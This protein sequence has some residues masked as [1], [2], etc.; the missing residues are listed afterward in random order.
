MALVLYKV[1]SEELE[2]TGTHILHIKLEMNVY[3]EQLV[4]DQALGHY[5]GF[6]KVNL[7]D[8]YLS[9]LCLFMYKIIK[10]WW[11]K[12]ISTLKDQL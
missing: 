2:K 1:S 4:Q 8:L 12:E 6:S 5:K 9:I 7:I 10:I 3:R 11:G